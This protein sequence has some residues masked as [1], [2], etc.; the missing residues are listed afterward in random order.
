MAGQLAWY[1]A[2]L[3]CWA[4]RRDCVYCSFLL[5]WP[6]IEGA[7][8]AAT[9]QSFRSKSGSLAKFTAILRASSFVSNFAA[10]RRPGFVKYHDGLSD[11]VEL[12]AAFVVKD[13]GGR[14]SGADKPKLQSWW[15]EAAISSLALT[16]INESGP[17][18][19]HTCNRVV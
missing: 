3:P 12:D 1:A 17:L 9:P 15:R 2:A 8:R 14:S 7:Q 11:C 6:T 4:W 18:C 16:Q 10:D 19:R 5:C 13:S